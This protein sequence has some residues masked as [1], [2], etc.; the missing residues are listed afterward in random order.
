MTGP[1]CPCQLLHVQPRGHPRM[2]RDHIG[3]ASP[4]MRSR[5]H[6]I[7]V[8]GVFHGLRSCGRSQRGDPTSDTAG[9]IPRGPVCNS[10]P[11]KQESCRHMGSEK[12]RPVSSG[13]IP[14]KAGHLIIARRAFSDVNPT[15]HKPTLHLLG[16]IT[17]TARIPCRTLAQITR[18][19]RHLPVLIGHNEARASSDFRFIAMPGHRF[20]HKSGLCSKIGLTRENRFKSS[21]S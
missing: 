13:G 16:I 4:F 17:A 2:T 8:H 5:K 20:S 6:T 7:F 9:C 10:L 12:V 18:W 3:A 14:G 15:G 1:C 19:N 11:L 21:S